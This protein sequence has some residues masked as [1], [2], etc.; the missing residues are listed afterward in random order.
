M[1]ES[2]FL[3]FGLNVERKRVQV[4]SLCVVIWIKFIRK[5]QQRD[6]N[7]FV[8]KLYT[9]STQKKLI[10]VLKPP[11][12][13]PQNVVLYSALCGLWVFVWCKKFY[14]IFFKREI[15][16]KIKQNK[17]E[18][19]FLVTINFVFRNGLMLRIYMVFGFILFF[20]LF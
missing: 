7:V 12:L 15:C 13:L 5:D 1:H 19:L 6:V 2:G 17:F 9:F 16:S 8:E 3:S 4:V 11:P 18:S 20:F 10:F 14:Y